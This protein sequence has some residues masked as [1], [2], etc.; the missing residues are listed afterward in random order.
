MLQVI[1]IAILSVNT[2]IVPLELRMLRL[3]TLTIA[4]L[5][6]SACSQPRIEDH[7]AFG[8]PVQITEFFSGELN[9]YGVVP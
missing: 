4:L 9:A 7:A 3:L 1:L 6:L 8:P 2:L 5:A